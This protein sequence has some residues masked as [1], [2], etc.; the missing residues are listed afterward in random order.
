MKAAQA[1]A[2]QASPPPAA[3]APAA[4][5]SPPPS[6]QAPAAPAPA[7][8]ATA[9]PTAPAAAAMPTR[10]ALSDDNGAVRASGV[11]RDDD[12][13]TSIV[14]AL[15]AVFG[16]DKVKS[17]ISVDPNAAAAPWLGNFRAALDALKGGNA[18]AIFVGDKVN[19]GGA[20]MTDGARDKIIASLKSAL[21]GSVAVGAL[22]DKTAAAVAV[23]N[24]RAT[25]ELVSLHSGFGVKDLLFALNDSVVNFPSGSADVP[26]S[27]APFL[28]T[29]AVDLK[30]LK[31]GHVLEI[32][33]YTDNTGDAALNLSLSQ[34]RAEAV[35]QALIKYGADPNMLVAKGY[36]EADPIASNDTAL[37]RLKNRRI[38][39]HVVKAPT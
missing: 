13:K 27:M 22:T 33:G 21:G 36:G 37:G 30:Q 28:K 8:V 7:T 5:A 15:N 34:K 29:A 31:P 23:A 17:D 32:A 35:R 18:D 39:Y 24:D 25:T 16:A 11:V 10:L 2:P 26:E 20:N 6:A 14:A 12:A 9:E 4:P 3:Q 1:T 19:V 38:E